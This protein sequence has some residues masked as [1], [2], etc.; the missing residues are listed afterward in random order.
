MPTSF[1]TFAPTIPDD[2]LQIA[3]GDI[4]I[5]GFNAGM[6]VGFENF[7]ILCMIHCS[8]RCITLLCTLLRQSG[9]IF[10]G[11]PAG[12]LWWIGGKDMFLQLL[13]AQ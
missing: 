6:Y 2:E 8:L 12:Y 1:T 7:Q 13:Y 9:L 10:C 3:A 11:F 4:A 5:S